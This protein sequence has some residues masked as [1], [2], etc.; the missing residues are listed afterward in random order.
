MHEVP[1]RKVEMDEVI[2]MQT[3]KLAHLKLCYRTSYDWH[4]EIVTLDKQIQVRYTDEKI[5]GPKFQTLCDLYMGLTNPESGKP[6]I[7]GI[8]AHPSRP[9]VAQIM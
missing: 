1:K 4:P 3:N 7:Q 2:E 9:G 8:V 5:R 6:L